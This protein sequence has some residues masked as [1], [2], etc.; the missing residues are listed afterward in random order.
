MPDGRLINCGRHALPPPASS[1][2]SSL[3]I[4][5]HALLSTGLRVDRLPQVWRA[6]SRSARVSPGYTAGRSTRQPHLAVLRLF[7]DYCTVVVATRENL[8]AEEPHF[9]PEIPRQRRVYAILLKFVPGHDLL[10]Y[11]PATGR[12]L[13][14]KE[15]PAAVPRAL[16]REFALRATLSS[17]HYPLPL[18][19]RG[20][21]S[22]I[23]IIDLEAAWIK[24]GKKRDAELNEAP[25]TSEEAKKILRY[26]APTWFPGQ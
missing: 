24:A 15:R 4:V 21:G 2:G 18:D 22:P 13:T 10:Q 8:S 14:L 23:A 1:L 6:E 11:F 3:D 26:W 25:F 19:N 12:D 9:G 17:A 5:L 16:L 7:H 20:L